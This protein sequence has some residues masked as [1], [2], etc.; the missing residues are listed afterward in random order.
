MLTLNVFD[1]LFPGCRRAFCGDG[2]RHIG[3]EECDGRDFGG[4][5]CNNWR[6]GYVPW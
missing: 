4:K 3:Y 1:F 6:R 2:F 5:T